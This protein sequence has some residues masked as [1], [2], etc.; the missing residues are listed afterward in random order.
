MHMRA[1]APQISVQ[2]Y[3]EKL[4]VLLDL[5]LDR[6]AT[7]TV[8]PE[9]FAGA[10]VAGLCVC[11]CLQGAVWMLSASAQPPANSLPTLG[12]GGAGC[13]CSCARR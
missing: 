7:F 13:S 10:C 12:G 2:G 9:R 5:L 11:V 6:L 3:S 4:P 1:P 8:N